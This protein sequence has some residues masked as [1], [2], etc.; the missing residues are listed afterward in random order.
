MTLK[1]YLFCLFGGLILLLSTFQIA[2]IFWAQDN[3][4]QQVIEKA[5][6]VSLKVMDI[7]LKD[8]DFESVNQNKHIS[9]NEKPFVIET[10]HLISKVYIN[11]STNKHNSPITDTNNIETT[12]DTVVWRDEPLQNSDKNANI[13]TLHNIKKVDLIKVKETLHASVER[14]HETI[15]TNRNTIV[16]SSKSPVNNKYA[17]EFGDHNNI[18]NFID[19]VLIVIILSTLLA[20]AFA[21]WLST[22]LS[23][24]MQSL[25][26]GFSRLAKGKYDEEVM[27]QGS[28]ET[29]QTIHDFNQMKDKLKALSISEKKLQQQNQLAELGEVSLGLAHALRNPIHTIGLSVEQLSLN[30][31]TAEN[32]QSLIT[33]IQN[34]IVH[35]D[36]TIRSLLSLTSTGI[37]RNE[38]LHLMG[39][40]QDI[41]LEY[42]ASDRLGLTFKIDIPN[43]LYIMGCENEIRAILHTLIIN[44]CEASSE[45]Q[46]IRITATSNVEDKQTIDIS[47]TD[48]GSGLSKVVENSLF[49][50]HITSKSE[51]AGM[52]LYTAQ[53]LI[54][55]FYHGN[56]SLKNNDK[57]P[58][59]LAIASFK[60][61]IPTSNNTKQGKTNEP[62]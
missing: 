2:F 33:T 7:A 30:N 45:K 55:L 18:D 51:G 13:N 4:K 24:P 5:E 49:K 22:H 62:T 58:G 43:T 56:I 20:L 48:E 34:K 23:K 9:D 12:M 25:S 26:K 35:I 44:A 16:F 40:V 39:I 57:K 50:P 21:Y 54:K 15:K 38:R 11:H 28:K 31:I 61:V 60:G 27:E 47:V 29:K 19:K 17:I 10:E 14:L 1:S 3:F 42:K 36:K 52:G 46:T 53:R 41:I 59:C 37:N 6:E 8:I 32:K